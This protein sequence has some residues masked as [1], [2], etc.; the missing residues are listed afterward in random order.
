[1][2]APFAYYISQLIIFGMLVRK[3]L[4]FDDGF[5]RPPV[6]T[7]L[8]RQY[9]A[10]SFQ[11]SQ[12]LTCHFSGA[13]YFCVVFCKSQVAAEGHNSR[14]IISSGRYFRNHSRN[15]SLPGPASYSVTVSTLMVSSCHPHQSSG[16]QSQL[17]A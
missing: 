10:D 17:L 7:A 12:Y 6:I 8:L 2:S 16:L 14:G 3:A 13:V 1:M 15:D 9:V 11:Y 5:I 4:S